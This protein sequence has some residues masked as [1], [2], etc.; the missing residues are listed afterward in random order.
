MFT[1]SAHLIKRSEV[2]SL[3]VGTLVVLSRFRGDQGQLFFLSCLT[4]S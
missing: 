2:T 4:G 1:G 3:D